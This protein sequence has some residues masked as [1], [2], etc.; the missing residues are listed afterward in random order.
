MRKTIL[1]VLI[2]VLAFVAFVSPVFA[3]DD[4]DI[5]K[6]QQATL[7]NPGFGPL[8]SYPAMT[9]GFFNRDGTIDDNPFGQICTIYSRSKHKVTIL[10][11]EG[12]DVLVSYDGP[13]E[14]PRSSW[15]ECSPE[16][17]FFLP[18]N[19]IIQLL[20]MDRGEQLEEEARKHPE[21]ALE[22]REKKW[23][24]KK[25]KEQDRVNRLLGQ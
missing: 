9:V 5:Q 3:Q 17:L 24:E 10:A 13:S 22:E 23:K 7:R 6:G 4:T 19:M 2:M 25:Q 11:V 12:D 15:M 18:K 8:D 1:T 20:R 21:R 16:N 14:K